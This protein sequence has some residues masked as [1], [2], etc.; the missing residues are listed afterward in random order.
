VV[1]AAPELWFAVGAGSAQKVGSTL[2]AAPAGVCNQPISWLLCIVASIRLPPEGSCLSPSDAR[3][4]LL[5]PAGCSFYIV[6][7]A[8]AIYNLNLLLGFLR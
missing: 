8:L 2:Q 6:T 3:A 7:Y 1:A 4:P 5:P